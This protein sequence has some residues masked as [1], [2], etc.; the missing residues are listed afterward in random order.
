M[1]TKC[2]II[3]FVDRRFCGSLSDSLDVLSVSLAKSLLSVYLAKPVCLPD[4]VCPF[5]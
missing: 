1:I 4:K 2:K 5:T 3:D